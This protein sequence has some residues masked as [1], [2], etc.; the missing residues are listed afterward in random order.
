[1][2][3]FWKSEGPKKFDVANSTFD[4]S[5][6]AGSSDYGL[7]QEEAHFNATSKIMDSKTGKIRLYTYISVLIYPYILNIQNGKLK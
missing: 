1:M 4:W 6:H 5:V 7:L 2:A 3:I